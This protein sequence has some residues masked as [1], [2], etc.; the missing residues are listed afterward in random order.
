MTKSSSGVILFPASKT[1]DAEL[2]KEEGSSVLKA[3]EY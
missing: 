1:E 2:V 3:W